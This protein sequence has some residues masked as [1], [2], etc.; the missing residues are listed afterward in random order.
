MEETGIVL[1]G[2]KVHPTRRERHAERRCGG[3]AVTEA[4]WFADDGPVRMMDFLNGKAS[5]RKL[6]LLAVACCYLGLRGRA[7][8]QPVPVYESVVR[9][10][11]GVGTRWD[12]RNFWPGP[13]T[14]DGDP[15]WPER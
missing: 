5:D 1:S 3:R 12:M 6:C 2:V 9:F 7:D 8:E 14:V 13:L 15:P 10:V 4:E 11:D